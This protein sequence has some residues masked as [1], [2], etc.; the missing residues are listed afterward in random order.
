MRA[1][2]S[3]SMFLPGLL[4]A[5]H[6]GS[7]LS[8][9]FTRRLR[10]LILILILILIRIRIRILILIIRITILIIIIQYISSG[11]TERPEI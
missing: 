3:L 4:D 7:L 8:R 10:I 6:A 11:P 1:L 2:P 5:L 9:H